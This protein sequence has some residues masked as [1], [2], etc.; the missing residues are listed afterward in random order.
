MDVPPDSFS[1][2]DKHIIG[3]LESTLASIDDNH[4]VLER[5]A[6]H[7]FLTI[8]A[9]ATAIIAIG[10]GSYLLSSQS[11]VSQELISMQRCALQAFGLS[12]LSVSLLFLFVHAP[13]KRSV[14]FLDPTK[15]KVEEWLGKDSSAYLH[16]AMSTYI[17][18][19]QRDDKTIH[20]K[21]RAVLLS[22]LGTGFGVIAAWAYFLTRFLLVSS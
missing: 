2:K 14:K 18:L 8:S 1:D 16:Q 12:H 17:S 22:T 9:A 15:E 7:N 19:C 10:S 11:S 4:S 5:K 3:R 13:R 21:G 6:Q 20:W